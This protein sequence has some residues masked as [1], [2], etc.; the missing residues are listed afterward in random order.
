MI[1]S[2]SDIYRSLA[3]DALISAIAK[4]RIIE[5][6]PSLRPE[7][8][9]VIYISK[10]PQDSEFEATW[11]L[12][13]VDFDNEPL[14]VIVG[15]I[16]KSFPSFQVLE[17]GA[18]LKGA[19]REVKTTRTELA[20]PRPQQISIE[21][22]LRTL[23]EKFEE[24]RE[25]I[26]DRMLLVNSGRPGRDG[27]DGKDGRPGRDGSPGRDLVATE[28]EL[29]D[30][31]DVFVEDAKKG[32]VLTYDGETWISR[33][34]EQHLGGG[35]GLTQGE[36]NLLQ[37][38]KETGEPTGFVDRSQS[39]IAFD[40][41]S[42]T[43]T[44]S[45]VHGEFI[46]W[47]K[48]K[49][50]V[51]REPVSVQIPDTTG[52]YFIFFDTEG[53]IGYQ[54]DYFYWDSEAPAAYIYW[55]AVAK[56][57]PYLADERHGIVLDWQTHEYLHRTRG[58]SFANGFAISNYTIDGDNSLDSSAQFD[59]NGGTFFDE[60]L[61]IDITHSETPNHELF[62]QDLK[63]P[64]QCR[65][66]YKIGTIWKLDT[67][68]N[69][70][71]KLGVLRPYYNSVSGGSWALTET[72]NNKYV[73]YY[74]V[75]THNLRAPIISIMGHAQYVN[76]ADAQSEDFNALDL[77]GFP[78]KEFRFLYKIILKTGN[79]TNSV[80]CVI[81]GVQD[82]RTYFG[83]FVAAVDA[84]EFATAAQGALA[85]TALQPGDNISELVNDAFYI[86]SSG[87]PVQSVAGKIGA[88]TLAKGDV[89]LG[90][91]DNTSD[92][93]KPVSTATQNALNL[94]ANLSSPVFSGTPTTPTASTSTNN[95]QIASTAFVRSAITIYA[96]GGVTYSSLRTNTSAP[97]NALTANTTGNQNVAFGGFAL[98]ANTTGGNN[99]GVGTWALSANTS[100][101]DNIAL[102]T[103]SLTSNTTGFSN[104]A[105]GTSS[106]YTNVLGARNVCIGDRAGFYING[107]SGN[108]TAGRNNVAIGCYALFN[109]TTGDRNIGIGEETLKANSTGYW[110]TIVGARAG[111]SNTDGFMNTAIGFESLFYNQT[112]DYN[113]ALGMRALHQGTNNSNTCIGAEAGYYIT[114]GGNN[115]CIG[116][117][118]GTDA[119][120][121]LTTQSNYVVLGNNST[122]NANIK[123]SWTVTSDARDKCNITPCA[124]G[125]AFVSSLKPVRYQ[126]RKHRDSDEPAPSSR[127]RYGF[128]AQDI[129]ELEGSDPVII[130]DQDL[131]NL[132]FNEAS[133][134][135]VL[136]NAIKELKQEVDSLSRQLSS[137]QAQ[138]NA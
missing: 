14:D 80:D 118:S 61:Q 50:F 30:L 110:N 16:R 70:A 111:I 67:A 7:D 125:L 84:G 135:P 27:Q 33:F 132:K 75:A 95:T 45:P 35:G 91:V 39:S 38:A 120:A 89:G 126:Y 108:T 100:G 20:P 4:V 11:L 117:L 42:R 43:I 137:I 92:L 79:F 10:Y 21:P 107:I 12:W 24:L 36:L 109:T 87:A 77:Q 49:R 113:T 136:V 15:Q 29:G 44:I 138:S 133:L 122:T 97:D 119:V 82:L 34:I 46:V 64:A 28:A 54:T 101:A 65:V 18:I 68:T 88:V 26:E 53:N 22:H 55:D 76:I 56:T 98:A 51:I 115:T 59:L 52:L 134:I 8:G 62:E 60:D 71:F 128:L 104:V 85:D 94:K 23:E 72:D 31:Q 112:G 90:N 3:G 123:V 73:N 121:T 96:P 93:N 81:A 114:S 127:P 103:A 58:A 5:G 86:T 69:F 2:S 116:I 32:Q 131:D 105:I 99:A 130:D 57:C 13:I 9:T 63:G 48:A 47:V 25:S 19:L 78:S 6:A 66:F 83:Q 41:S 124:S 40:D 1:T 129:L 74:I 106:L 102:G 37:G 17:E